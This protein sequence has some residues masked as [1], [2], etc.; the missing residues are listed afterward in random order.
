M[1]NWEE[2]WFCR[3]TAAN[4]QVQPQFQSRWGGTHCQTFL[5]QNVI[6]W[7]F[8]MFR[9][10]KVTIKSHFLCVG[11]NLKFLEVGWTYS[12]LSGSVIGLKTGITLTRLI[13]SPN[14]CL[15]CAEVIDH[16]AAFFP[17]PAQVPMMSPNGSVPPIYVPPGYVSQVLLTVLF[18]V[19]CF[20]LAA[21]RHQDSSVIWILILSCRLD[22]R[23]ERSAAGSGFTSAA[24]V[25]P[26]GPLPS[27]SPPTSTP[28]SPACLHPT[29]CH[30]APATSPV[31]RPRRGC[32]WH[33]LSVQLPVPSGSY[34]LRA[35]WVGASSL[36]SVLLY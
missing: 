29:P 16:L 30:D 13:Y 31:H 32:G 12:N 1:A 21:C 33:E 26:G 15:P 36:W 9:H 17:G 5:K 22:H 25:P 20:W 2:L 28:C 34:L 14:K 3:V 11:V 10:S 8:I 27:P 23:R 7:W 18:P 4:V 24:R 6:Y 19:R 35:G